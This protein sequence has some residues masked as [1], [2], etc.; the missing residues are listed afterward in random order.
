MRELIKRPARQ[1]GLP[2]DI[3]ISIV[4][5]LFGNLFAMLAGTV[6][7]AVAVILTAWKVQEPLLWLCAVGILVTGGFRSLQ[8]HIYAGLQHPLSLKAASV[9]EKRYAVLTTAYCGTLGL[10]CLASLVL[11]PDPTVH[12]LCATV[13]VANIAAGASRVAGRPHIV[14]LT[15]L[16]A[17]GPLALGLILKQDVYYSG[18]GILLTL[19][20]LGL[21][22]ITASL[23]Q[24]NLKG[25]L[26]AREV[27]SL[28]ARFDTALNNMPHGLC[29]CEANGAILVFNRRLAELL[30]LSPDFPRD[31]VTIQQMLNHCVRIGTLSQR[32]AEH[33]MV[34]LERHLAGGQDAEAAF[35][36]Q[37]EQTF[38]FAVQVM[39]TGGTV[40]VVEDITD[41]KNAEAKINHMARFDAVTGLPNRSF[42]HDQL[43]GALVSARGLNTCAVLFIDLDQFKQ[44]ND[45]MGHPFG[46]QLLCAVAERLHDLVRPSDIVARF[47]GD[48][49]V[50]FRSG[51]RTADEASLL[52]ELIVE[53]LARPYDIDHHQVVIGA[54]IGI[55]FNIGDAITADTLMKYADMALYR[56]KSDGRGTWRFF[57]NEMAIK[58]Q[59][60]RGLELD[61]RNAVAAEAFELHYQP[62]LN[63]KTQR[64]ST[65][66][67]LLRWRHPERGMIPPMEFIPLAE[68]MGLIGAIGSFVLR[69][70]CVEA[71]RWPSEVGIAVNLSPMQFKRGDIYETVLDALAQSGLAPSRL[72]LEITESVLLQDTAA[73]RTVLLRLRD[74]GIRIS[75]DDFGT[76]YSSL[77]Y[78][79]RFPLQKVKIDRSFLEGSS[80]G[81]RSAKL[82]HGIARL[83]ASLGMSVV[84]EGIETEDQLEIVLAEEAIDEAQGYLFSRPLP[85]GQIRELLKVTHPYLRKVA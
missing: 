52:A 38:A 61:L 47:G 64:I 8:L 71:A 46:D 69:Q 83:S 23:H 36:I 1:D 27:A 24:T 60:R 37:G 9:W 82:L 31:G 66:E 22:R 75:L 41:R 72:E 76:G 4:D 40:I 45:T 25:L 6:C 43:E 74:A 13:T 73:T 62:L 26:A 53:Q 2:P 79:H 42:F 67:A 14:I 78:L 84:I 34:H 59:S 5:S 49:F 16:S 63:L 77:S 55:A 20:F 70:A 3:Y 39:E 15:I 30:G 18:L 54:S 28:A 10:W 50:V 48:E 32:G 57:E 80:T 11:T 85:Q 12:L 58:A 33:V 51:V 7:V 21:N 68:E 29:M 81:D 35:E 56:A 17:C 19:F 65:C 44:V